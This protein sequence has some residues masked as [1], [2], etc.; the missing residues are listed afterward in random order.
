M[1]NMQD[2]WVKGLIQG[3]KDDDWGVR[4]L[5]ART[6]GKIGPDAKDAV[7]DSLRR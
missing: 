1:S 5:G 2:R 7:P 3:L 6:L 4:Y